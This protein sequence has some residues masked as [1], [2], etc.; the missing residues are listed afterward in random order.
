MSDSAITQEP[1]SPLVLVV[2]PNGSIRPEPLITALRVIH[3]T[4][5]SRAVWAGD[6]HLRPM[7]DDESCWLD[8]DDVGDLE[9]QRTLVS[10]EPEHAEWLRLLSACRSVLAESGRPIV[11]LW[12]GAI[13]VLGSIEPL[14]AETSP[15]VVVPRRLGP[16]ANDG[17]TP[18]ESDLVEAGGMSPH[19]IGLRA[20]SIVA[21]HWLEAQV[22]AQTDVSIGRL[23]D[24]AADA[25]GFERCTDAGIGAGA[26]RWDTDH[27]HLLDAAEYDPT[28]PW[29]LDPQAGG[30]A[31]INLVDHPARRAS[32]AT[33]GLQLTGRR[34][35]V[36]APGAMRIDEAARVVCRAAGSIFPAPWTN[37]GEFR[38]WL[39]QRYWRA[40]HASRRDL[41]MGFPDPSG[42][43]AARFY[44]WSR[45]AVVDDGVGLLIDVPNQFVDQWPCDAP[46]MTHGVNIVGYLTRESSLGDVA[47][48]MI[49]TLQQA[50]VSWSPLTY[51]RTASPEIGFVEVGADTVAFETTVAV[52]NADQFASLR[53]DH[54]ELFAAGGRIIGYWFWELD[55]VPVAMRSATEFV[56]EIWAGSTFVADAFRRAAP[57]EV[58]HVPIPIPE[59]IRSPRSRAS[60]APLAE[61][62]GRFVFAVVFDHFS[63]TER[64]NPVGAIEAFKRAFAPDEGPVLVVKSM[65]ADQRWPQHQHVCAAADGRPDIIIW[66]EHLE[67]TDHMA[68]IGAVDCL[69]SLHRSEGLGLHLA[70]AMWLGTPVIATRYSGNLDFMDDS[71][72]ALIDATLVPV[73]N[74]EG[75][76]PPEGR[77]ADP[78]LEQAAAAM[79]RMV[80]D[81]HWAAEL[82]A[83]ARGRMEQQ[84]TLAHAGAHIARLLGL[85]ETTGDPS[86]V[87]S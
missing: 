33:A 5:D 57:V 61:A 83:A 53:G 82:G 28:S 4:W 79:R 17:C 55:H 40:L 64:K 56:D 71:C 75:V 80:A 52:V 59:P 16:I 68:L 37:P 48:R 44:A 65:N 27:P 13:A 9:W 86:D 14:V 23:L 20:D 11:A 76:Y 8:L 35:P 24:R 6:P 26:W 3:P 60:F 7:L 12:A 38:E 72:A 78:D 81:P 74:G 21:V 19:M 54:P 22:R 66:D 36:V 45:R 77:W 73:T 1:A 50:A 32:L 29:V 31:R 87:A 51:Q 47:R 10:F 58:R 43:D 46:L 85:R 30:K 69:V 34:S 15:A 49:S 42:A 67:R 25:Y 41:T 62:D 18:T 70:E 39:Q 2:V 84:P 63:V